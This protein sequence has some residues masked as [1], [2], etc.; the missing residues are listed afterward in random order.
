MIR[1]LP[2][3]YSSF[4][5]SLLLL[6]KLEKDKLQA[7]Q[8][9]TNRS[10][11][12]DA[13]LSSTSLVTSSPPPSSS[14]PC[15]FC[16]I[17]GHIQANCFRYKKAM[18]NAK[19]DVQKKGSK[20]PKAEGR[21]HSS[22]TEESAGNASPHDPSHSPLQLDAHFDWNA[23]TGATSHMTPHCHWLCNYQPLHIPIKLADDTVVYSA[24][25]DLW[26]LVQI[27]GKEG[28]SIEFSCV[29][30]VPALRT[31]LLSV[32]FLSRLKGF[33]VRIS[34]NSMD[35]SLNGTTLFTATIN[36]QNAAFLKGTTIAVSK[37]TKLSST[38]PMDLSLWHRRLAHHNYDD[39]ETHQSRPCHRSYH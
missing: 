28:R 32:L 20:R 4:T 5:S 13:I 23:D 30:N 6:D 36:E 18:L 34:A 38:L 10:C 1:S 17:P 33:I 24:G 31:N 14:S 35:F 2:D 11:R 25:L 16:S 22:I 27:G 9:E 26:C 7:F 15:D 39:E 12:P 37:F 3:E 21:V 19:E 29:L 8:N